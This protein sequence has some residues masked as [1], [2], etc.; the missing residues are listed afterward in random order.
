MVAPAPLLKKP[1]PTP[2][3]DEGHLPQRLIQDLPAEIPSVDSGRRDSSSSPAGPLQDVALYP[4]VAGLAADAILFAQL[5][6]GK[7]IAQVG[8]DE[9]GSLIHR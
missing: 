6:D 3:P 1:M 8:G 7:H 5:G 9:V 2:G 4:L